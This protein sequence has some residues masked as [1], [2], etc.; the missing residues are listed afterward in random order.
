MV[1]I[2][3]GQNLYNKLAHGNTPQSA[4][5]ISERQSNVLQATSA[6]DVDVCAETPTMISYFVTGNAQ[7]WIILQAH[8]HDFLVL[9]G[10]TWL[11]ASNGQLYL[12]AALRHEG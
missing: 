3:L 9:V 11:E 6:T 8:F 1:G 12:T 2:A 7:S 5:K 10:L 4:R